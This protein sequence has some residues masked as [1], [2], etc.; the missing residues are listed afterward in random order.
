MRHP[1]YAEYN[2]LYDSGKYE[3]DIVIKIVENTAWKTWK[4]VNPSS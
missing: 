4:K 1:A 2:S 3:Q